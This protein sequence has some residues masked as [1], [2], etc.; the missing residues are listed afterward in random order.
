MDDDELCHAPGPGGMACMKPKD[1]SDD[2]H[3]WE[4]VLP[5]SVA[6]V[7]AR[8]IDLMEQEQA[9][10]KRLIRSNTWYRRFLYSAIGVYIILITA[11]L[12]E[13]MIEAPQ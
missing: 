13:V 7:V 9:R 5:A 8:N 2:E 3:M 11:E 12:I 4:V 1:H 6:Q 10:L